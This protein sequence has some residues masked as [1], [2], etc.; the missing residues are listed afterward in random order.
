MLSFLLLLTLEKLNVVSMV[1]DSAIEEVIATSCT[2]NMFQVISRSN[3]SLGCIMNLKVL[4]ILWQQEKSVK[5]TLTRS[6]IEMALEKELWTES[7][8]SNAIKNVK[9]V[10][11]V[12]REEVKENEEN[13]VVIEE[14]E[15]TAIEETE[16]VV[17]EIV[18]KR[19]LL[20]VREAD[21]HVNIEVNIKIVEAEGATVAINHPQGKIEIITVTVKTAAIEEIGIEVTEDN[22]L[23][24]EIATVRGDLVLLNKSRLLSNRSSRQKI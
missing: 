3:S 17:I 24:L 20:D 12:S 14:I 6:K 11:S 4:K 16:T 13:V 8:V 22:A 18:K 23:I 5:K 1:K 19:S 21:L 2:L 7:T 10:V 15:A 9:I